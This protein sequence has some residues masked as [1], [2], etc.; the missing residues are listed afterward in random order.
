MSQESVT[1]IQYY[2]I[3]G[4]L[5]I[6]HSETPQK[7]VQSLYGQFTVITEHPFLYMTECIFD[8]GLFFVVLVYILS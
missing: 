2:L 8:S 6:V 1:R 5:I 3:S 4:S 7:D